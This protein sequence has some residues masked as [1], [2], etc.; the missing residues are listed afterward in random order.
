MLER[1]LK[2]VRI[3]HL[4]KNVRS[5][6]CSNSSIMNKHYSYNYCLRFSYVLEI[7]AIHITEGL[8]ED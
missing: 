5:L 6:H 4:V 8:G 1:I 2:E 3:F 7:I